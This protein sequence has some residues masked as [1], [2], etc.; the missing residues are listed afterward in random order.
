MTKN[1]KILLVLILGL[2]VAIAGGYLVYSAFRNQ[3]A[4]IYV[5][6]DNYV[7]GTTIT[8]DM[9]TTIECDKKIVVANQKTSVS[10]MFVSTKEQMK[11]LIG[12]SLRIS[13]TSGMPVMN[14]I[15]MSKGGNQIE[16]VMS[17]SMIAVTVSV[18]SITGVTNDLRTGSLVDICLIYGDNEE[19]IEVLESMRIIGIHKSDG[20]SLSAVT[21]ETD[22]E[23]Y[24]KLVYANS[25]ATIHLG[26]INAD[27]YVPNNN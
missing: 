1:K 4:T 12:D 17:D 6:N 11:A 14:S 27:G 13:V 5:F 24:K 20:V 22:Y 19:Q 25:N 8:S 9:V 10:S 3:K 2:V 23:T 26:L 7:A 16:A 21:F 18:N 15:A